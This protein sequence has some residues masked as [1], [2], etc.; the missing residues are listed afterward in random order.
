MCFL[1]LDPFVLCVANVC[2]LFGESIRNMVLIL[3]LN[4][5]EVFRVGG[6]VLLDRTV[7]VIQRMSL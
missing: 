4:G 1:L 5:M 6:G 2:Q 7:M 3:L